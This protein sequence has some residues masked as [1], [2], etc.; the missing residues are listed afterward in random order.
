MRRSVHVAYGAVASR[1]T[2]RDGRGGEGV[3][4]GEVGPWP[5]TGSAGT[6]ARELCREGLLAPVAGGRGNGGGSRETRRVATELRPVARARGRRGNLPRFLG[7]TGRTTTPRSVA[8]AVTHTGSGDC[9]GSVQVVERPRSAPSAWGSRVRVPLRSRGPP[10][11]CRVVVLGSTASGRDG[12]PVA[13]GIEGQL[14]RRVPPSSH[15]Q[16]VA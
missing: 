2:P 1:A 10:D 14:N 4:C 15:S 7:E 13:A 3:T 9:S 8:K 16:T 11:R 5:P 6:T 12:G